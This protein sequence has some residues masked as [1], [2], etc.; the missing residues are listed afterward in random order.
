M[1]NKLTHILAPKEFLCSFSETPL[2]L[3]GYSKNKL[4][5]FFQSYSIPFFYSRLNQISASGICR[6]EVE[7]KN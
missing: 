5:G 7:F 3:A 2:S 6:P 4:T 1:K